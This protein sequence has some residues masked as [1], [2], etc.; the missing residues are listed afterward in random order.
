MKLIYL[1]TPFIVCWVGIVYLCLFSSCVNYPQETWV[2]KVTDMKSKAEEKWGLKYDYKG[3]LVHYG[4]TAI[5]YAEDHIS[6][7]YM[8]WDRK[9]EKMFSAT[10]FLQDGKVERSESY[11]MMKQDS[12]EM[13]A[14]KKSI[15]RW[16][17]D[18]LFIQSYYR[19][20]S[21]NRLLRMVDACYI[22]DKQHRL[23]EIVSRYY[24]G[25]GK[26]ESACHSYMDY[27]MPI[28]YVANLNLCAYIADYDELDIFLFFL[29][30][31]DVRSDSNVLPNR[32]RHCVNHG[33]A[34]YI[35]DALYR[36]EG[37]K[38]IHLELISEQVELKE[39]L[40]FM[41]YQE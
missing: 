11:G 41:Y 15:F 39:R 20:V 12:V 22:Y 14:Y 2:V 37:E 16:K 33:T 34:T 40:E 6:V 35:A 28:K 29:I 31:L 27:E 26:E 24:N 36:L 4:N 1:K 18:S 13:E 25:Q 7:G 38:V 23:V 32:I 17:E 21:D 30:N 9:K 3:R 8:E 10:Y 5:H 19:H